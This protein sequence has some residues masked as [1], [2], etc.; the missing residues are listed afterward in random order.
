MSTGRHI[1]GFARAGLLLL[2]AALPLAAMA[3]I[4][5]YVDQNGVTRYTDKPPNKQATPVE[6]PPIQTYT[7]DAALDEPPAD[8][9]DTQQAEPA[10]ITTVELLAPTPEQVFNTGSNSVTATAGVSPGLPAGARLVFLVDGQAHTAAEG[11]LSAELTGLSR[12]SHSLQAVVMDAANNI[13]GQSGLI[14]FHMHQPSNL[15]PGFDP[16]PGSAPRPSPVPSTPT[17]PGRRTRPPVVP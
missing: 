8:L 5:K 10:A 1:T 11:Q 4:Y 12:G 17:A 3:E 13:Q 6:L 14:N 7:S 16:T 9:E 2:L 15:Q